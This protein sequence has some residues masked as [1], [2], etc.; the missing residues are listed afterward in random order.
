M[1]K[2]D[3]SKVFLGGFS[4]G[5]LVSFFAGL[6]LEGHII[7][8]IAG[9]SGIIFPL[10]EKTLREASESEKKSLLLSQKTETLNVLHYHGSADPLF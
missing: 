3:Y 5:C 10:L 9:L 8:G 4:Q 7:G 2:S 6:T 1:H